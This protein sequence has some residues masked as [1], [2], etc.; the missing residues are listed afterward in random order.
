MSTTSHGNLRSSV[1][2]EAA[3]VGLPYPEV[4][5][6]KSSSKANI[7]N[8]NVVANSSTLSSTTRKSNSSNESYDSNN[9]LASSATSEEGRDNNR[10]KTSTTRTI[11]SNDDS[12]STS[13][14]SRFHDNTYS[15]ASVHQAGDEDNSPMT[16]PAGLKSNPSPAPADLPYQDAGLPVRKPKDGEGSKK[17]SKSRVK[18][19]A[20]LKGKLSKLKKKRDSKYHQILVEDEENARMHRITSTTAMPANPNI[21]LQKS[22]TRKNRSVSGGEEVQALTANGN[23]LPNL[24]P[25]RKRENP[26]S[27]VKKLYCGEDCAEEDV[28]STYL[29]YICLFFVIFSLVL[30]VISET[31]SKIFMHRNPTFAPEPTRPPALIHD[32]G[33]DPSGHADFTI[34]QWEVHQNLALISSYDIDTPGTPQYKAA[35]WILHVDEMGYGADS[36]FLFQR[37]L[38]A[39]FYHMM[40]D[41]YQC[42]SLVAGVDE[43]D[44]DRIDCDDKGIVEQISFGT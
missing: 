27:L 24:G 8:N 26:F 19:G 30:I 38:L 21:K 43:C 17:K 28:W 36:P 22:S 9:S 16:H 29:C 44:W 23:S 7:H 34:H 2:S 15:I 11:A 13:E 18:L 14:S 12:L 6:D 40:E 41:G 10:H 31:K 5:G 20:K 35:Q 37:F 25:S 33:N 39:I 32:H 3:V 4:A 42:F 1:T